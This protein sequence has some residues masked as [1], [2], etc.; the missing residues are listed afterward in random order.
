MKK[1]MCVAVLAALCAGVA[2]GQTF[3]GYRYASRPG[4]PPMP[5]NPRPYLPMF[6]N[7]AG[8]I[9]I[10]DVNTGGLVMESL[11]QMETLED[12]GPPP[13]GGG[14]YGTNTFEPEAAMRLFVRGFGCPG[15]AYHECSLGF[16]FLYG[17]QD[18]DGSNYRHWRYWTNW[19]EIN[20]GQVVWAAFA[21]TNHTANWPVGEFQLISTEEPRLTNYITWVMSSNFNASL[22]QIGDDSSKQGRIHFDR[23]N[24]LDASWVFYPSTNPPLIQITNIG[25]NTNLNPYWNPP[26]GQFPTNPP[27]PPIFTYP[28]SPTFLQWL[29]ETLRRDTSA[30]FDTKFVDEKDPS[31]RLTGTSVPLGMLGIPNPSW[32][33]QTSTN[34]ASTNWVTLATNVVSDSCG[35]F[36]YTWTCWFTNMPPQQFYRMALEPLE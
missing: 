33:I 31:R 18:W 3:P 28:Y 12:D 24:Q 8:A 15:G 2:S 27:A 1:M 4:G 23:T 17:V 34:L 25:I 14:D 30:A 20:F 9:F 22:I 21:C 26:W 6:T 10:D 7:E 13:P 35:L 19:T 36:N 32:T 16:P 29:R 11:Y 5:M